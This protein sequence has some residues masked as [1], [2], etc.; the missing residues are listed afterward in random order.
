MAATSDSLTRFRGQ[1]WSNWTDYLGRDSPLSDEDDPDKPV[2]DVMRLPKED[3]GLFGLC[4]ET[5]TFYAVVCEICEACVKPQGLINHMELWH[6]ADATDALPPPEPSEKVSNGKSGT[7]KGGASNRLNV[8]SVKLR[9]KRPLTV[10]CS[11]LERLTTSL[12]EQTTLSDAEKGTLPPMDVPQH[13]SSVS[14]VPPTRPANQVSGS[15]SSAPLA[16]LQPVVALTPLSSPT[17]MSNASPSTT[18]SSTLLMTPTSASTP[19]LPCLAM[20]MSSSSFSTP[21]PKKRPKLERK[22]LP[23]KEREYDPDKHCGVWNGENSKPC[24]RSL[25]CKSHPLS[26]RRAVSGRS[27][28]FDKLLAD[29]RAAK[30][31]AIKLVKTVSTVPGVLSQSPPQE[32]DTNQALSPSPHGRVG[33]SLPLDVPASPLPASLSTPTSILTPNSAPLVTSV[34]SPTVSATPFLSSLAITPLPSLPDLTIDTFESHVVPAPALKA[35][36]LSTVSVA[37]DSPGLGNSPGPPMGQPLVTATTT[38]VRAPSPITTV[39]VSTLSGIPSLPSLLLPVTGSI[40]HNI[41]MSPRSPSMIPTSVTS[42][43]TDMDSNC[44]PLTSPSKDL[45]VVTIPSSQLPA[46][47][48]T[49][50]ISPASAPQAVSTP[51]PVPATSF[52]PPPTHIFPSMHTLTSA[53]QMCDFPALFEDVTWLKNH[54]RPLAVC[55]FSG[56]KVGTLVCNTRRLEVVREGLREALTH[57]PMRSPLNNDFYG[58]TGTNH[59]AGTIKTVLTNIYAKGSFLS[60]S[61]N[62]ILP[63]VGLS[64]KNHKVPI[65]PTPSQRSSS[66]NITVPSALKTVLPNPQHVTVK[67]ALNHNV[68]CNSDTIKNGQFHV[69]NI[70]SGSLKRH[71]ESSKS[72]GNMNSKRAKRK[73]TQNVNPAEIISSL[74]ARKN[75]RLGGRGNSLPLVTVAI[76]N[77]LAGGATPNQSDASESKNILSSRGGVTSDSLRADLPKGISSSNVNQIS[78]GTTNATNAKAVS[79]NIQNVRI[80]ANP[81]TVQLATPQITYLTTGPVTFQQIPVLSPQ[82]QSK[83]G[84]GNQSIPLKLVSGSGGVNLA[85]ATAATSGRSVV[86]HQDKDHASSE[87]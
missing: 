40:S 10:P 80:A 8:G 87:S 72:C 9:V 85:A 42:L 74:L 55:S 78:D 4:P 26:M 69:P 39:T 28:H 82:L 37:R 1:P 51:T 18:K 24:T 45:T 27:K 62:I 19:S 15:S 68:T 16:L 54:P 79:S 25:T 34:P 7:S 60:P 71:A 67:A 64:N 59:A 33:G 49:P 76:A 48:S 35:P 52:L 50:S 38:T 23:I 12:E 13:S 75:S 31:A 47:S 61:G 84:G 86:L 70:L 41:P 30:D 29:H 2:P 43:N 44:A 65:L 21:S 32:M 36:L 11:K 63:G 58:N 56:R 83:N 6:K 81:S 57:G 77:G 17:H 3:M 46:S 73:H 22:C 14:N 53:V 5:D 20:D 66:A